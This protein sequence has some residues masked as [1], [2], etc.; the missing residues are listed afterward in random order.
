MSEEKRN[1]SKIPGRFLSKKTRG[2]KSAQR[3]L[4]GRMKKDDTR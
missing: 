2:G 3:E 4:M 1:F